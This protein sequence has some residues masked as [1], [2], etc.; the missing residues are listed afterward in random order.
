[1]GNRRTQVMVVLLALGC[2][3]AY[4]QSLGDVARAERERLS[5]ITHHAPRLTDG[6]LRRDK[7]LEKAPLDADAVSHPSDMHTEVGPSENVSLGDYARALRQ[8]RRA[9]Q[10]A[11]SSTAIAHPAPESQSADSNPVALTP[12]SGVVAPWQR[13]M[14]VGEF[15]R[16]VRAERDAARLARM[17]GSPQPEA[18]ATKDASRG[19]LAPGGPRVGRTLATTA[20]SPNLAR[21]SEVDPKSS[22]PDRATAQPQ[23]VLEPGAMANWE[24]IRVPRGSSLWSLAREHL[25]AGRL[26][27]VLWKENPQIRDPN[28][29]QAG[30]LLRC[31]ALRDQ[32]CTHPSRRAGLERSS[33]AGVSPTGPIV[34]VVKAPVTTRS[35]R[36]AARLVSTGSAIH[37]SEQVRKVLSSRALSR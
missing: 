3:P 20:A 10:A 18:H 11:A 33:S 4:G 17:H 15:A 24:S 27:H 2:L 28:R 35:R 29:I 12:L 6:D 34:A 25:G 37:P 14:S 26:W 1:M 30:Q 36:R 13:T 23:A 16:R 32:E 22:A 21:S 5:K 8:R 31:P 7:I 9:E 19:K